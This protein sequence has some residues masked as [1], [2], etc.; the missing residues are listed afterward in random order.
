MHHKVAF[1]ST[2]LV[3]FT[4]LN[5][6][7]FFNFKA[8]NEPKEEVKDDVDDDPNTEEISTNDLEGNGNGNGTPILGTYYIDKN[9]Q[10]AQIQVAFQ[11]I[12]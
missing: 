9:E 5:F 3:L 2:F 8:N 11:P 4:F 7:F 6:F 1:C 10:P 12:T